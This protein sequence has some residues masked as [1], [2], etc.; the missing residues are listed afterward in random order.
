MSSF[1]FYRWKIVHT[2]VWLRPKQDSRFKEQPELPY[3]STMPSRKEEDVMGTSTVVWDAPEAS[4]Q[5]WDW[6]V[7]ET[8]PWIRQTESWESEIWFCNPV[9]LL[10]VCPEARGKLLSFSSPEL[11]HLYYPQP[12]CFIIQDSTVRLRLH[13]RYLTQCW[14][15]RRH[16][17]SVT[18]THLGFHILS[19]TSL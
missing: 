3:S 17:I 14:A 2:S 1:P 15:H 16:S 8:T 19:N 7:S 18:V 11:P 4:C 13:T 9:V 6:E 10:P 5:A 12:H